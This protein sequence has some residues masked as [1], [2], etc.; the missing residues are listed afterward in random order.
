MSEE[1]RPRDVLPLSALRYVANKSGDVEVKRLVG[2][3]F[4]NML[5]KEARARYEFMAEIDKNMRKRD[6]AEKR[7]N[8]YLRNLAL[9]GEVDLTCREKFVRGLDRLAVRD[10]VG[11]LG[12][13]VRC[14]DAQS[15]GVKWILSDERTLKYLNLDHVSL[16][17]SNTF[18]SRCL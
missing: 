16:L 12:A 11:L 5:S 1:I 13:K 15:A 7:R 17:M 14:V 18:A 4:D 6:I 3:L 10:F 2:G 8:T 9:K